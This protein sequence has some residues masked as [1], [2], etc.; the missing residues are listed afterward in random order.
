M[1]HDVLVGSETEERAQAQPVPL[2]NR[3]QTFLLGGFSRRG[4]VGEDL[5]QLR[6]AVDRREVRGYFLGRV[7]RRENAEAWTIGFSVGVVESLNAEQLV[8]S[9]NHG[10]A[11][12]LI[13][14]EPKG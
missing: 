5:D 13:S 9:A 4:L 6:L 12:F 14:K 10:L 11:F 1:V 7:S 8:K 2:R 3:R